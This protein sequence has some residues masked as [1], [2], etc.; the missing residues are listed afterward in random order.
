MSEKLGLI[1]HPDTDDTKAYGSNQTEDKKIKAMQKDVDTVI[2]ITRD[3]VAKAIDR[4]VK[5]NDLEDKSD[6]LK[7]GAFR[8][9]SASKKLKWQMCRKNAKFWG[10]LLLVIAVFLIIIII[11]ATQHARNK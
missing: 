5:L 9:E 1:S 4:D 7:E 11:L 8:F 3:N 6:A 10:I 2:Q